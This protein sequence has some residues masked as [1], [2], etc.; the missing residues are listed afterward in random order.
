MAKLN[1]I[2][3]FKR[4]LLEFMSES[5]PLYAMLQWMTEKIMQME[6]EQKVGATKGTHTTERNTYFSGNRVRRFDTRL[7][8]I[9]LVVP[10][11]RKGGYIPFFVTE[12]KRSEAALVEV[13]QEA[14]INGV[15][16]RKIEQLAKKLGV[17]TLSASQV[18]ELN[19]GLDDQVKAFRTRS[20]AA[21]Y[22]ILWVDA[23]Y[24]K[25]RD[26]GKVISEAVLVIYGVN[27]EGKRE[28]LAVEPMYEES[29]A[30]W[31]AVLENLK[32]R[33]LQKVWLVVSDAHRGIQNAVRKHLL[34]TSWQRCKV[35]L[36]RN[37][38]GRVQQK[39][40]KLFADKLKQIWVQ[41]DRKSALR[42]AKIFMAEHR[43]KYP[44]A[45]AVLAE[46]LEDSL[47]FFAFPEFDQRK[48]AST[49]VLER[50]FREVR[51]RSRV[52][53]VFP[54]DDAY[55]RLLTCY[56]I[57]YSEDWMSERNYI[58]KEAIEAM[59]SKLVKAA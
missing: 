58:R 30:T 56:L 39:D 33:G 34:G 57:E 12:R 7:G 37:V 45:V 38:M 35:H 59:R 54:S 42:T 25:I 8:T 5:D 26:N 23:V 41:P 19:K 13:V 46:G 51:R 18:S 16:T 22:P 36:M 17:E 6:A 1:Y 27:L 29:E 48:I 20:L 11:L 52:V 55:I 40:K 28:I 14:Y 21:E 50:M 9:Y 44:D 43:D 3:Y 31:A 4:A 2:E 10:K 49:N 53:G 32:A 24:E 47:Q 15:S